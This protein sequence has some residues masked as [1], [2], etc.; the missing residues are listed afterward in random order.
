MHLCVSAWGQFHHLL[1]SV[2]GLGGSGG[3]GRGTMTWGSGHQQNEKNLIKI[4]HVTSP[5]KKLQLV[6]FWHR[7][8]NR[9]TANSL[10]S[11]GRQVRTWWTAARPTQMIRPEECGAE[12]AKDLQ[13]HFSCSDP[14]IKLMTYGECDLSA[15][16]FLETSC[17]ITGYCNRLTVCETELVNF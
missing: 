17:N 5:P 15:Q 16:V 2:K 3:V 8:W 14:N 1:K 4:S 12:K 9:S 11:V 10:L 7:T 6:L 13:F